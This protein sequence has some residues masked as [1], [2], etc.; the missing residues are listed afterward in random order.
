[1]ST[2]NN[3]IATNAPSNKSLNQCANFYYSQTLNQFFHIAAPD[4]IAG[5]MVEPKTKL[6]RL[7]FIF[8]LSQVQE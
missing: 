4:V 7:K 6:T 2:Q 5:G 1:M 3:P 8:F